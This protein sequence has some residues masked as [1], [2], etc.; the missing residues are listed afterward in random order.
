MRLDTTRKELVPLSKVAGRHA[1]TGETT[2]YH[3]ATVDAEPGVDDIST[4]K[5]V[6]LNEK[7]VVRRGATTTVL[8]TTLTG[9]PKEI[10]YTRHPTTETS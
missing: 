4:N 9:G 8:C 5:E 1:T 10:S 3:I 6:H 7:T 2:L